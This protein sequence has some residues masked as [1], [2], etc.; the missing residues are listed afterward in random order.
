MRRSKRRSAYARRERDIPHLLAVKSLQCVAKF[1]DPAYPCAGPV[2]AD[3][4]GRRG[5]SQKAADD[6]A[7]SLCHG[8]HMARHDFA[9]PFRDWDKERMR[10]WLEHWIKVTRALIAGRKK[11]A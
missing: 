1:L 6:T 3:H 5:I 2:E 9:G 7:I 4:A 11:A 8:H 10:A